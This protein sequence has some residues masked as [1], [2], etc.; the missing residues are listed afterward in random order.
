MVAHTSWT[1]EGKEE[2]RESKQ[3]SGIEEGGEVNGIATRTDCG[4]GTH[5]YS[6]REAASTFLRS[7]AKSI[8]SGCLFSTV[9]A[10]K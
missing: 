7:R 2:E 10:K 1:K 9:S 3:G 5:M 8:T 6:P 4:V